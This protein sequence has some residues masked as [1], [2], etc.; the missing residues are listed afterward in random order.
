MS[1]ARK[2][3]SRDICQ[4]AISKTNSAK[5]AARYLG[6][7]YYTFRSYSKLYKSDDGTQTLFESCKNPA[8]KNI[9]K[10]KKGWQ[11]NTFIIR[12][13]RGTCWC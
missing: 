9:P 7:D 3:L 12:Y 2:Y 6:V 4:N 11:K 13:Y 1:P 8:G 10:F 5:A